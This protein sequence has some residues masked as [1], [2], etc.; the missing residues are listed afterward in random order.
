MIRSSVGHVDVA[1]QKRVGETSKNSEKVR[2]HRIKDIVR[3]LPNHM[4]KESFISLHKWTTE[5]KLGLLGAMS[6]DEKAFLATTQEVLRPLV[7]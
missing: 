1:S 3:Y 4:I 6:Q 5:P 7:R 2:T